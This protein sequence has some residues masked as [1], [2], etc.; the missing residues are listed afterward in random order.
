MSN[1]TLNILSE[2]LETY[3]NLCDVYIDNS[4]LRYLTYDTIIDKAGELWFEEKKSILYS[5]LEKIANDAITDKNYPFEKSEL[6]LRL[7]F[8]GCCN[9]YMIENNST[10]LD[11]FCIEH[12]KY[13]SKWYKDVHDDFIEDQGIKQNLENIFGYNLYNI[14]SDSLNE[15]KQ[16]NYKIAEE[17]FEYIETKD[18]RLKDNYHRAVIKLSNSNDKI[19]RNWYNINF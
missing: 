15:H 12:K 2:L 4:Q 1:N 11:N 17:F 18:F 14:N 5:S 10:L 6:L 3:A 9:L 16:R 13:L 7:Y 19:L 8:E